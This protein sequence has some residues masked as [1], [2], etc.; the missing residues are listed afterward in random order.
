MFTLYYH[1]LI[2]S[3]IKS[4]NEEQSALIAEKRMGQ[5]SVQTTVIA[6]CRKQIL[7]TKSHLEYADIDTNLFTDADLSILG[8]DWETYFIYSRNV[9]K[10]YSIYYD[11][12]Y[13][14][15]RKKVLKHFLEKT[16]IYKTDYFYSKFEERAKSNLQAEL[17]TL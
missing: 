11:L 4:D 12:I 9:R 3:A 1:D 8:A 10:E 5:I 13:N 17:E 6:D 16:R 15:G 7:A 2:Y 14:S